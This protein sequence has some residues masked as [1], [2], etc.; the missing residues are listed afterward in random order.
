MVWGGF[1]LILCF[2][3]HFMLELDLQVLVCC[4]QC[5]LGIIMDIAYCMAMVFISLNVY[6]IVVSSML[7]LFLNFS[8]KE[9]VL[10]LLL[11]L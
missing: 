9:C 8:L 1:L 11:L 2:N 4:F 6:F 10:L 3:L 5:L 7:R